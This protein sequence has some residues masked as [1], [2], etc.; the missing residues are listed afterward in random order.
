M[1]VERRTSQGRGIN[2]EA[3]EYEDRNLSVPSVPF[4]LGLHRPVSGVGTL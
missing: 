1:S 2:R 3:S 4:G